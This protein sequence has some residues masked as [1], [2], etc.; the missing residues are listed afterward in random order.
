MDRS[1][2]DYKVSLNL[3]LLFVNFLTTFSGVFR[4]RNPL[5]HGLTFQ[6]LQFCELLSDLSCSSS[7]MIYSDSE[8]LVYSIR[9]VPSF[10]LAHPSTR[11]NT[12]SYLIWMDIFLLEYKLNSRF[13]LCVYGLSILF[14][15]FFSKSKVYISGNSRYYPPRITTSYEFK[16][17]Q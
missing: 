10:S 16:A 12:L 7:L 17:A 3:L 14:T 1:F 4:L 5:L 15:V 2:N 8:P 13:C 6:D 9:N 11:A